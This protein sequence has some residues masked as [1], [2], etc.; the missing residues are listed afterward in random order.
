MTAHL[1]PGDKIHIM[2]PGSNSK[3][4]EEANIL[5][6]RSEYAAL[7][8]EIFLITSGSPQQQVEIVS[9]VREVKPPAIPP[10]LSPTHQP[11]DKLRAHWNPPWQDPDQ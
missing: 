2:I 5:R 1:Q 3:A 8:I 9:I 11:V 10:A 6:T 7:G 4:L